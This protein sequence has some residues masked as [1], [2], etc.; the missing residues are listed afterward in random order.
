MLIKFST[1]YSR[2]PKKDSVA[3][4]TTITLLMTE[5]E[6][7]RTG[8]SI[9]KSVWTTSSGHLKRRRQFARMS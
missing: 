2:K 1:A 8:M 5:K 9:A 3:G 7:T 6:K 4:T